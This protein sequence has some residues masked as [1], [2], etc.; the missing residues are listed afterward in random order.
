VNI[1][2]YITAPVLRVTMDG[3][4][5]G[6]MSNKDAQ[7]RAWDE[8][9]DLVEIAPTANPPVCQIMDYGKFK[10]EQG[11]K[12]KEQNKKNQEQNKKNM[13]K[14]VQVS[15]VIGEHDLETK[16]RQAREF[17]EEGRPV[18]VTCIF[19]R[20][21]IMFKDQGFAV[22][23][24]ITEAVKDIGTPESSPRFNE[25]RLQVRFKPLS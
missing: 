10:F 9:L 13:P 2:R 5:L 3:Q 21:Q 17:L 22:V 16:I 20:R 6:V 8:G 4:N 15:P 1:N 11:K 7:Q 14:E 12:K 24:K 23:A 18:Q 25:K 19:A